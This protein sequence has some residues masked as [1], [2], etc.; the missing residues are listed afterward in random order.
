LTHASSLQALLIFKLKVC[1]TINES[2]GSA[3]NTKLLYCNEI[4]LNF[5][6]DCIP[7][8]DGENDKYDFGQLS[9]S[10][11]ASSESPVIG[12]FWPLGVGL[13][14]GVRC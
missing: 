5:K 10:V 11:N 12:L 1:V 7:M 13:R 4:L 9:L 8:E 6:L 3:G 2:F 14:V